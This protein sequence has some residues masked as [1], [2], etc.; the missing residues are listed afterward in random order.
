MFVKP[1]ICYDAGVLVV[2]A[3]DLGL[4]RKMSMVESI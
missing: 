4:S 1:S 3:S 2:I